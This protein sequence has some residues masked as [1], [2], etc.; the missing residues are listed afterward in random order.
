MMLLVAVT[1]LGACSSNDD[2]WNTAA[3]VTVSMQNSTMS[4]KENSGIVNV[5]IVVSGET[6]GNVFVTVEVKETGSNPAKEDVH[7]YVT[8][9]TINI[10]GNKGNV[11]I[12]MVDDDDINEARTFEVSIVDAKGAK[13]SD[14]SST[15][16]TIKDNDSNIYEK[17]QG[18][19][20]MTGVDR[21]GTNAISW[22]VKITGAIDESDADYNKVLYITG[23]GGFTDFQNTKVRLN[24]TFNEATQKGTLEIGNM[25]KY[26]VLENVDLNLGSL[27]NVKVSNLSNGQ[28]TTTSIY[29]TWDDD[30]KNITFDEDQVLFAGIYSAASDSFLGYEF[31]SIKNI[32]MTKS[33]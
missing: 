5:P 20:I 9:K 7:Y 22:K 26:N 12:E 17:L 3:D 10:S 16:I 2:K 15:V 25:Q 6:N 21:T 23:M 13:I 8:D 33:K 32:K 28:L 30:F 24:Y 14:N 18:N 11:E 1:F 4:F 31:F 27:C 29:G 19:W